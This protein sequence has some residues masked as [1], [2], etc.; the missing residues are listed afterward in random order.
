MIVYVT[1]LGT[2]TPVYSFM[3][4]F[5]IYFYFTGTAV[6][7]LLVTLRVRRL[8]PQ[9]RMASVSR[10]M[11]AA[12]AL[13]FVLGI[14]NLVQKAV[15]PDAEADAIEN[16]IEWFASLSMQAWFLGLYV[17]WRRTGVAIT[18]VTTSAP[19]SDPGDE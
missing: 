4:R 16:A 11:L 5:G 14:G 7:Q 19:R 17:A 1:F 9:W 6:A 15:L 12:V 18:T 8:A 3:R 13:P 2:R 10:W